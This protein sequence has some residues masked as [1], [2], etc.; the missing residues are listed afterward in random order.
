M[1]PMR[2]TP[3]TKGSHAGADVMRRNAI[4]TQFHGSLLLDFVL[5]GGLSFLGTYGSP[6]SG[7]GGRGSL[8]YER[9]LVTGLGAYGSPGSGGAGIFLFLD[10]DH[11]I[12]LFNDITVL[13]LIFF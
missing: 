6:G 13:S 8:L 11:L 4:K 1:R 12:R 7:T 10:I 3:G 5:V 9:V 2:S